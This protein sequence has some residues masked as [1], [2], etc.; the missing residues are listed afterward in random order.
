[1]DQ[2]EK[3]FVRRVRLEASFPEDYE[4]DDEQIGVVLVAHVLDG[5]MNEENTK[6]VMVVIVIVC[7]LIGGFSL[8]AE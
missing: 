3:T 4:G 6:R 5:N 8:T 2:E 1:M 7:A